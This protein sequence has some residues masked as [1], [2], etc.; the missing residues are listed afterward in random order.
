MVKA[1]RDNWGS[2]FGFIMAAAGSAIG[3]GNIWRFPYLTGVSGGGA[4][5]L[6]YAICAIFVGFSI[7]LAEFTMGRYT[8][9][10]VV[11]AY[12][13]IGKQWTFAGFMG[14]VTAVMIMGFYPV[15]GGWATAYIFKSAFGVLTDPGAAGSIF[16]GF[17]SAPIEPLIWVA[18]YMVLNIVVVA[19]GIA[20]GIE[21]VTKILMPAL[22]ALLVIIAVRGLTLPGSGAG[23][24]FLFKPDFSKLDG[25]VVLAALGQ[26]FFSLSVGMGCMLTYGSFLSKEENL[27]SNAVL[28]T[29]FDT[30]C[31]LVA[32]LAMFPALFAYGLD[33][34]AG[35]GLIFVV[36]PTVFAN[37]GG[38]GRV[39]MTLFFIAFTFAAWSSSISLFE[40]VI[41]YLIEQ[42][43]MTRK[44][45]VVIASV[46]FSIMAILSSLSL[47]VL[48]EFHILGL[49][50]FDLFDTV[51]DKVYMAIG[52]ALLA[53][54]VGWAIP[55]EELRKEVT[56]N[57]EVSFGL[58]DVWH[59]LLRY[60]IPV[61]VGIIS[62]TGMLAAKDHMLAILAG[63]ISIVVMA[64]F[65]KKMR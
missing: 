36:M 15:V 21:K 62:I 26:S 45:G 56:N 18:I 30:C 6:V 19:K 5:L 35:P 12:K 54:C 10:A 34:A 63:L 64:I 52:G 40:E 37:M 11:G 47:G 41:D 3:L 55:K 24:S 65:S 23:V 7:M 59:G 43:H 8:G 39:F 20:G 22:F 46:L 2:K 13:S 4:F 57:G 16:E 27:V 53:I 9:K 25:S 48:S 50:F 29:I 61:V 44:K 31:A 33:P 60:V 28:V 38:I 17:M 49:G 51:T 58:F 42:L 14:I 1:E 32:G